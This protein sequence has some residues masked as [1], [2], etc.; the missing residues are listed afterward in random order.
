MVLRDVIYGRTHTIAENIIPVIECVCV[1]I[2]TCMVYARIVCIC[3]VCVVYA[4]IVCICLT[5]GI[6]VC[7]Y[8]VYM[9][10]VCGICVYSVYMFD[11]YGVCMYMVSICRRCVV[12]VY[13]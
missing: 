4:S 9:Y 13:V 5:C 3:M 6:C 7:V 2:H 1:Y 11:V 8:C 12:Y 10:G